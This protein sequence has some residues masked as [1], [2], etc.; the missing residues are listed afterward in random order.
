[1]VE[2]EIAFSWQSTLPAVSQHAAVLA[3]AI[4]LKRRELDA[5][6][7]RFA[8]GAIEHRRLHAA[9]QLRGAAADAMQH[10]GRRRDVARF[11]RMAGADERDL[12]AG[13][14]EVPGPVSCSERQRLQGL[15]GAARHGEDMRIARGVDHAAA[16]IDDG[17]R[18][19]VDAIGRIAAR[20][21]RERDVRPGSKIRYVGHGWGLTVFGHSVAL[22]GA[23]PALVAASTARPQRLKSRLFYAQSCGMRK[24]SLLR[25]RTASVPVRRRTPI[26]TNA[27]TP[28][29][30]ESVRARPGLR[31]W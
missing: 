4:V 21:E 5:G 30:C 6:R 7:R 11:S 14:A 8:A 20:Y 12:L 19:V 24:A 13:K 25:P 29:C 17:D 23:S 18:T 9:L 15:Q 22:S 31:W 1:M 2:F 3:R 26:L 28:E 27:A 16:R 10:V